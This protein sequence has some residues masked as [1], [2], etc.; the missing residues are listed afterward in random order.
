MQT[1]DPKF[2]LAASPQFTRMV[3]LLVPVAIA[4]PLACA[5]LYLIGVLDSADAVY[6]GAFLT[7]SSAGVALNVWLAN[8]GVALLLP[9]RLEVRTRAGRR[10]YAWS[11]ISE[12]H[13]VTR[14]GEASFVEMTL[15]SSE[16]VGLLPGQGGTR[17]LGIPTLFG[18]TN[19]LYVAHPDAFVSATRSYVGQ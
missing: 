5:A 18:K 19:R 8:R 17:I 15:N 9:E 6:I 16:K 3:R 7:L 1:S 10:V 2:T 4:S 11:D 12:V 13:V 14:P